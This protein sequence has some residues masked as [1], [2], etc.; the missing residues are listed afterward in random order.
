MHGAQRCDRR[1]EWTNRSRRAAAALLILW[2]AILAGDSV[3]RGQTTP[4]SGTKP[5]ATAAETAANDGA[6]LPTLQ[7]DP[8]ATEVPTPA[9]ADLAAFHAQER[10]RLANP[11]KDVPDEWRTF[12]ER[13]DFRQT[14]RYADTIAYCKRLAAAS[15]WVSYQT[16]GT[17][18][19]G[20]DLAL[21]VL[22]KD[23]AF[24]PE[25]AHTTGK[26]ILLVQNC[27][28]AGEVAGKDASLMLARD[29]AI[30]K[31]RA[32]L[33]EHAILLIM[34]MFS[35]DGHERYT[36]YSRINQDGPDAMGWRV[37]AQN[38]NLNRD[39][40][41]ADA[42]E[43]RG[44]LRVFNTWRPH[45]HIDNHSTDGGDWQYDL[46]Y[47][48]DQHAIAAPT[49]ANWLKNELYAYMLPA[50]EQDG[51]LTMTYFSPVDGK[52]PS[53]GI[54]SGGWFGPR[55]SNSYC[56]L[57]NRPSILVETHALKPYRTRVIGHYNLMARTLEVMNKNPAAL[58]EA[59]RQADANTVKLVTPYE[60]DRKLPLTLRRTPEG[61]PIH[62]RGFAYQR[63]HS[64][65]S[66]TD[67]IV[68]QRGVPKE[69]DTVWYHDSVVD[70][71]ITLPRGYIIPGQWQDVIEVL[72]LHGLKCH[73]LT[74][75]ASLQVESYRFSDVEFAKGPF[76]G[77][78]GCRYKAEPIKETRKFEAGSVIVWL[79]QPDAKLAIHL[80]EPESRDSLV[81]WGFFNGIFEQ[82]EYGEHYVLE[83]LARKMLDADPSL[84]AEFEKRL[85]EDP[86]FAANSRARLN[87]FYHRSPYWDRLMN[88]YP[89]GRLVMSYQ[90]RT[91][92][93]PPLPE[94]V[95]P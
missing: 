29:I 37:T 43:M 68:Y 18:P 16:F 66:G 78:F 39:Y 36:P 44:W 95:Y 53:K 92:P 64:A 34:P 32:E 70:K 90:L 62:F 8:A 89:V 76:E 22:S 58:I 25:A 33:L 10:A 69:F 30:T 74:Q 85:A 50:L 4:P 67:R 6:T 83:K 86:E 49:I 47:A 27:I 19:Q 31:T 13:T 94:N 35:V 17:S 93:L 3:A 48:T 57:R 20:R 26:P 15:P 38:L 72:R 56:C 5:Q 52:D 11:S 7:T 14:P 1:E 51:H 63:L 40:A 61:E 21:L 81:A 88:V 77:R 55:F 65:I 73:A 71:T 82:K 28:H 91:E 84:A 23:Q 12:C 45:L 24:T 54:R 42:P 59:T 2:T 60:P 9:E 87:F 80:L 41:K 79:N 46:M 75:P